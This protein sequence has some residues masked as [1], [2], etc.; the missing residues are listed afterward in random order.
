MSELPPRTV[1][2]RE[3]LQALAGLPWLAQLLYLTAIRPHM[4]Y[5]LGVAGGPGRRLSLQGL[6]ESVEVEPQSGRQDAGLP[7]KGQ[8]RRALGVLERAGVIARLADRYYLVFRLP[9]AQATA[10]VHAE[11]GRPPT[12]LRHPEPGTEAAP[13]EPAYGGDFRGQADTEAGR[14]PAGGTNPE[15]DTHRG[16]GDWGTAATTH[17]PARPRAVDLPTDHAPQ[18]LHEWQEVFVNRFGYGPAHVQSPKAG[19]VLTG[20]AAQGVTV[21]E[22]EQALAIVRARGKEQPAPGYLREVVNDVRQEAERAQT[23]S[24]TPTGGGEAPARG[25]VNDE[26]GR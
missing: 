6:R 7:S 3:E 2:T 20:W 23:A 11:A 1:Y 24:A 15:A 25:G 5:R 16:T 10:S 18:N 4:D 12:H 13:A 19:Q 8:V 21:G 9:L 22:V 26:W 14:G 17:A